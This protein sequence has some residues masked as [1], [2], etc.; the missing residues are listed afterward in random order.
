MKTLRKVK[1]LL[2]QLPAWRGRR[3]PCQTC[4]ARKNESKI[5]N[6]TWVSPILSFS[7]T[8]LKFLSLS[9][10]SSIVNSLFTLFY[11]QFRSRS[12]P[13]FPSHP[14]RL[15]NPF[16][17]PPHPLPHLPF[18]PPYPSLNP[19]PLPLPPHLHINTNT[20]NTN[21][22]TVLNTET[23]LHYQRLRGTEH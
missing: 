22:N 2:Y 19:L 3:W 23:P 18:N 11:P 7:L 12:R 20:P 13:P 14:L 21:A 1:Q 6:R 8:L 15:P 5:A 16:Q 10:D 17:P 9:S 4:C